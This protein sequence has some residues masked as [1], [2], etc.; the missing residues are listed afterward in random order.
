MR[1]RKVVKMNNKGFS[2]IEVLVAVVILGLA[3][4]SL[5]AANSSFT[6]INS[7]GAELSTSEFLLEQLK[8]LTTL[9]PVVDPETD[10]DV[11]GAEEAGLADY[12]DLDDFDD[13]SFSPPINV[14]RE[15]LT[16]FS[17]Y[18]QQVTVQN[19]SPS[20]LEQV[21]TDHSSDFVRI[22]VAVSINSK[23]ICSNSWIRARVE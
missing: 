11:F 14:Q 6:Q 9:L 7:A 5:I 15:S 22:T 4:A 13:A 3:I 16:M 12:D 20:N 18:T 10:D 2:L 17:K 23:Q 1:I 21:V 8:E 19:I